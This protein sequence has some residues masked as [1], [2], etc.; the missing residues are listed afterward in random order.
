MTIDM[1][2]PFYDVDLDIQS[3]HDYL[4]TFSGYSGVCFVHVVLREDENPTKLQENKGRH[5]KRN[6]EHRRRLAA[7]AACSIPHAWATDRP[8]KPLG[9]PDQDFGYTKYCIAVYKSILVWPVVE[10][11]SIAKGLK[12]TEFQND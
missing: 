7:A 5:T 9:I 1:R 2:L 8:L 11:G 4:Y 12:D 3:E 10:G 6:I